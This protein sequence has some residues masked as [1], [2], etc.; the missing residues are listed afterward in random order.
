MSNLYGV[1]PGG[2]SVSAKVSECLVQQ[3]TADRDAVDTLVTLNGHFFPL[4]KTTMAKAAKANTVLINANGNGVDLTISNAPDTND[5]FTVDAAAKE[6]H[7]GTQVKITFAAKMGDGHFWFLDISNI[8]KWA[9]IAS[10]STPSSTPTAG[11]NKVKITVATGEFLE[12]D[13]DFLMLR[14][15][16]KTAAKKGTWMLIHQSTTS[17]TAPAYSTA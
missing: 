15:I 16:S 5:V 8:G 1:C 6:F 12:T 14:C 13:G 4:Q 9:P 2:N 17:T 11:N 3:G 7:A 10:E